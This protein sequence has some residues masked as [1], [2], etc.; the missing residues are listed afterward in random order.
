MPALSKNYVTVIHLGYSI[1]R[2]KMTLSLSIPVRTP[3]TLRKRIIE[4]SCPYA[5]LGIDKAPTPK[6]MLPNKIKSI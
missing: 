3:H 1:S 4:I 5:A 2:F 6:R